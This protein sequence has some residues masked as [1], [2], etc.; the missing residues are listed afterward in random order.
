MT[1]RLD[2]LYR[3]RIGLAAQILEAEEEARQLGLLPAV[4][5]GGALKVAADLYDVQVE[6]ILSDARNV[7]AARARQAVCWLLRARGFSLPTIGKIVG[8]DHTTVLYACNKIDRDPAIRALLWPLL[9]R[10][11]GAA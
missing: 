3:L 8:R 9:E 1:E 10:V 11:G 2:H 6:Q 5:T 7:N 4:M